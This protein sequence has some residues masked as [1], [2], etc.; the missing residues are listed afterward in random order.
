MSHENGDMRDWTQGSLA[1]DIAYPEPKVGYGKIRQREAHADTVEAITQAGREL[2][3]VLDGLD[4]GAAHYDATG[5][6]C[7][8]V[9]YISRLM[10]ARAKL[11]AAV[12]TAENWCSDMAA[13][14]SP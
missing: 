5:S 8:T 13:A 6:S 4:E 11:R 2:T 14:I 12:L 1:F 3:D 10:P 7:V 9:R